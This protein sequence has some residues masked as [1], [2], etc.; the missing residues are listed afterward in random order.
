MKYNRKNIEV[1]LKVMAL[2]PLLQYITTENVTFYEY[3]FL[4]NINFWIT[5]LASLIYFKRCEFI[6]LYI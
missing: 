1:C 3:L 6:V 4:K 5:I 2:V